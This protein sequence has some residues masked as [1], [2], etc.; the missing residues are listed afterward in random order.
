MPSALR[1]VGGNIDAGAVSKRAKIG[2]SPKKVV[3]RLCLGPEQSVG[4][5][6]ERI[7]SPQKRILTRSRNAP[8]ELVA[9]SESEE[10][11]F[12]SDE[13]A[14]DEESVEGTIVEILDESGNMLELNPENEQAE[15][16][17]DLDVSGDEGAFDDTMMHMGEV[18][19]H[20]AV[21]SWQPPVPSA[22]EALEPGASEQ[23]QE[24]EEEQE[25][26][27][28][29]YTSPERSV[30]GNED[31]P[32]LASYKSPAMV[33]LQPVALPDGFVSPIK[34]RRTVSKRLLVPKLVLELT[35]VPRRAT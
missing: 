24:R 9:L 4:L 20:E 5:Q 30:R 12:R 18:I 23:K 17:S 21:T 31:E 6:F 15:D 13:D 3:K 7:G 16:W 10:E 33:S 35:R 14:Q 22:E 32:V 28:P 27:A 25:Q 29:V 34:R 1:V 2:A 19:A 26:P 8:E 11:S